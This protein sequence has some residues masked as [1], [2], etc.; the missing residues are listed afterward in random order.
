MARA[1][2]S[3]YTG[4]SV[5]EAS[6]I[7]FFTM[8]LVEGTLLDELIPATGLSL[9]RLFDVAIPLADALGAAH[10]KGIVHR[11]LKPANI[12][13]DVRGGVKV[14]DFGLAKT[15]GRWPR[16]RGRSAAHRRRRSCRRSL[17]ALH[18]KRRAAQ[19]VSGRSWVNWL[20][21]QEVASYDVGGADWDAV[22]KSSSP[23]RRQSHLPPRRGHVCHADASTQRRG[24]RS[25]SRRPMSARA[26]GTSTL[27][28]GWA[29]RQ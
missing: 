4:Y 29:V 10:D 13:V 2:P 20:N 17:P 11:D 5:E 24:G 23:G 25:Y 7:Q 6:G 19:R 21:G 27:A 16:A 3:V 15:A 26:L 18:T 12:M 28:T 22:I 8:E 14:L 1:S 9:A